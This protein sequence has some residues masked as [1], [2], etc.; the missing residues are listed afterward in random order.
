VAF[1]C[2]LFF[3]VFYFQCAVLK[4]VS[5]LCF[6]IVALLFVLI[7]CSNINHYDSMED[8]VRLLVKQCPLFAPDIGNVTLLT[9]MNVGS[10]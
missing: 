1:H 3:V 5:V 2:E 9:Y 4:Y 8:L 10:Q 6:A 7:I